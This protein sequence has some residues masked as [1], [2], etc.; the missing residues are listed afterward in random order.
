M[1]DALVHALKGQA[2]VALAARA[3]GVVDAAA[4]R[5]ALRALFATLTNVNFDAGRCAGMLRGSLAQREALKAAAAAAAAA[6]GKPSPLA[7]LSACAS[8][9]PGGSDDASL[10][11]AGVRVGVLERKAAGLGEEAHALQELIMYG[12]KGT[13]AFACHAMEAGVET[14]VR[15]GWGRGGGRRG[16]GCVPDI[17]SMRRHSRAQ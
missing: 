7:G 6:A 16:G 2:E 5:D 4:D 17:R 15:P 14:E 11:A 12:V 8:W 9:T 1:Q 3:V 13:A 10:E